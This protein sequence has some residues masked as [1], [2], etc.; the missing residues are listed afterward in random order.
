MIKTCGK[1]CVQG[2]RNDEPCGCEE[3]FCDIC[4]E[5]IKGDVIEHPFMGGELHAKCLQDKLEEEG[6]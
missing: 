5:I 2:Y 1:C 3:Y 6:E 4:K